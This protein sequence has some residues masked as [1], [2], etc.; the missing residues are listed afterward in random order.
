MIIMMRVRKGI[1][2]F[3]RSIKRFPVTLVLALSVAVLLIAES[4]VRLNLGYSH[5]S[6]DVLS[7]IVMVTAL[8]IPFTLSIKLLFEKYS[9]I[10]VIGKAFVYIILSGFLGF[11]YSYLLKEINNVSVSRYIALSLSLYICF[12][13]I[14]FLNKKK[15]SIELYVIQLFTRFFITVIYSIV[16]FLGL[17]AILF[18][19]DKLLGITV[20]SSIYYYTWLLTVGL[21]SSS[22]FLAGVPEQDEKAEEYPYP[23]YLR[24][25]LLYIVIPLV[26]VYLVILYIY[27][28]KI[29]ITWEWPVGLVSHLVLWYSAFCVGLIFLISILKDNKWVKIFVSWLPK[30]ILPILV[31]M[32]ISMGIRINAYGITENRYYVVVLGLWVAAMMLFII[33][34]KNKRNIIILISLSVVALLSVFGPLSSF[35]I[36]KLSQNNRLAKI[37]VK[38][39]MLIDGKIVGKSDIPEYDKGEISEILIYFEGNHSLKDV[40][41]LERDF[42]LKDMEKVFGFEYQKPEI[43]EIGKYIS[44]SSNI[45]GAIDISEYD[46]LF[47]FRM[48]K[49][50]TELGGLKVQY[51]Y[52][53]AIAKVFRDDEMIYTIELSRFLEELRKK[54]PDSR[55]VPQEDMVYTE[56]NQH[57]K[58][59]LIFSYIGGTE[60]QSGK[61]VKV[62]GAD[63]YVLLKEK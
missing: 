37:L 61:G 59:K 26:V 4:E 24:I 11:Y 49:E 19:V 48:M 18:T 2:S 43:P 29:I 3:Y 39:D 52:E 9:R 27:F 34:N 42:E 16:L 35:N 21:F 62:Q 36:S 8:G 38:N 5:P 56:E 12:L 63:F 53:T 15:D 32:F 22:F 58:V 1:A 51:N 25:L 10:T 55:E 44:Y 31:M 50:Q 14:P 20:R 60:T 17:A 47:D 23:K 45:I 57:L 6:L 30:L 54:Y 7:R 40:K 13:F 33:F 41:Y 28:A 46:Y